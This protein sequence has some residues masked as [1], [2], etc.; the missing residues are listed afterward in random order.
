MLKTKHI[1][2]LVVVLAVLVGISLLQKASHRRDTARPSLAVLLDGI[3]T[4]DGLG[5][6]I[7]GFGEDPEAVVLE[8]GPDGWRVPSH[9]NAQASGDRVDAVL[10]VL[11]GLEGEFRSDNA[12]VLDDYGLAGVNTVT[13]RGF[14]R[15]GV[16]ILALDV[17]RKVEGGQGEF[18]RLPGQDAVYVTT[19]S[20]L[21]PLGLY[22][23]PARPGGRHFFHL[24]AVQED[25]NEVDEIILVD[26]E[27]ERR[28]VKEFAVPEPAPGDTTG[29][30]PA[31]DRLTWEW[32]L[33][34]PTDEPLA[35]TK[36]D[37][38]LGSLVTIRGVDVED[39]AADPA[40]YGLD[41]PERRATLVFAGGRRLEL[42][43]GAIR[44]AEPDRPVG[45]RMRIVGD[46]TVWVVT[47][48]TV[49]NIF[50]ATADLRPES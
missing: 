24:E 50:K 10:R 3:W 33:A 4:A 19:A 48:Y 43:F 29:V 45:V 32:R 2:I 34:V 36:A 18:V 20:V 38:V 22:N 42:E 26:A 35:K 16:E 39:S 28:L 17:G 23:G 13:V 27:G 41:A 11:S 47:E 14:D 21:S 31:P 8:H 1:G 40:T 12:D 15:Q 46:P 6:L 7:V 49:N 9:W 30:E 5:R 44:E 25:R 37:G